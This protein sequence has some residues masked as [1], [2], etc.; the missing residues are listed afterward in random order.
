M[1]ASGHTNNHIMDNVVRALVDRLTVKLVGEIAQHTDGYDVF[2]LYKDLFLTENERTSMFRE[3][4]QSA[5][6]SKI[7]CS[8]EEKKKIRS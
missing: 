3:D 1:A 6:L 7:G 8:A 5:Y 2:K 4:I